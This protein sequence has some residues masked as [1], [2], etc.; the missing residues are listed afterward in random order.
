[1]QRLTLLIIP[2]LIAIALFI[3]ISTFDSIGNQPETQTE[4]QPLDY[5][6]YSE[7]I[8]TVL[9]DIDGKINY[10]LQATRQTHYNDET[11]EFDNPLIKLYESGDSRWN[12][13]ANSGKISALEAESGTSIQIIELA[14]NVEVHSLDSFGN[15]MLLSTEYLTLDPQLEILETNDA[16]TVVTDSLQQSSIGMIGKLKLDEFTFLRDIRGSYEQATN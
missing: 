15:R 12:I 3:G 16:V 8:N 1:M 10:T 14:G 11:T 4:L 6:A 13:V 2:G 5:N 9:Y 7:G